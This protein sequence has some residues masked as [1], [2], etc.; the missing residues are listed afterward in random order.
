[1]VLLC[2]SSSFFG[3]FR[4]MVLTVGLDHKNG[5]A[6]GARMSFKATHRLCWQCDAGLSAGPPQ[7]EYENWHTSAWICPECKSIFVGLSE[8]CNGPF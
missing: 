1:M 7:Y 6:A 8:L 3:V 4:Q 2:A 5:T